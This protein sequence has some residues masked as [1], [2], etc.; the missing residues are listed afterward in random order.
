[1]HGENE[2]R[3]GAKRAEKPDADEAAFIDG[4]D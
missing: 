3:Q 4:I 2:P 1:M